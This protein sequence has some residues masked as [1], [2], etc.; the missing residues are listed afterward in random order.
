MRQVRR[1]LPLLQHPLVTGVMIPAM[2]KHT[3]FLVVETVHQA[4]DGLY[5]IHLE[6]KPQDKFKF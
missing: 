4:E 6:E 5:E 1:A 3:C 2:S